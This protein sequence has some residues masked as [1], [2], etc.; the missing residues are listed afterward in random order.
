MAWP[1]KSKHLWGRPTGLPR[2]GRFS[3]GTMVSQEAAP[4][5]LRSQGNSKEK[6][7]VSTETSRTTT[8]VNHKP[9]RHV[10]VQEVEREVGLRQVLSRAGFPVLLKADTQTGVGGYG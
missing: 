8:Y 7:Q 4:S 2:G 6:L 3:L 10:Q 5:C 1:L 9:L